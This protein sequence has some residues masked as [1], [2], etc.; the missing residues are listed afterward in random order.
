MHIHF[1]MIRNL[2]WPKVVNQLARPGKDLYFANVEV[3]LLQSRTTEEILGYLRVKTLGVTS[4]VCSNGATESIS[5][6]AH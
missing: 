2:D 4:T 3:P 1:C 5:R 6:N